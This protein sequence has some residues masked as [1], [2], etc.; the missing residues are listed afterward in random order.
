MSQESTRTYNDEGKHLLGNNLLVACLHNETG[1]PV[2]RS[3]LTVKLMAP[4]SGDE[5]KISE[6]AK[7]RARDVIK[8]ARDRNAK[9]FE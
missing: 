6:E 5:S 7:W 9:G 2:A 4:G 8:P 3:S 1:N